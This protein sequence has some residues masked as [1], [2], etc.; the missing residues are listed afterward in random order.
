MQ[1]FWIIA[2]SLLTV[3]ALVFATLNIVSLVAHEEVTETATFDAAG[4]DL[5][6]VQTDNGTIEVVGADVDEI[7]VVA[8]ISH[9]LLRTE[10]RAEVEGGTLVVG[11][12]CADLSFSWCSVDYD[13][14]VPRD[15]VV[16]A[17]ADNGRVTL[18][19]LA[20][21]VTVDSDNGRIELLRVGGSVR[22]ST[23]NGSVEGTGLR[24][25]E[26]TATS[27]NGSVRLS[28]AEAPTMVTARTSNGSVE[29]TVP[30]DDTAYR[31]E[32]D[33]DHGSTDAGVRTDPDSRHVIIATTSNGSARVQYATG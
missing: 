16:D 26:V 8:D 17:D 21:D 13:I 19:D 32:L 20:G 11:A 24:G 23:D 31:V 27:S 15:L 3:A 2:G 25:P 4:I 7:S 10:H 33:T 5:L 1:R 9:G 28:F 29:V 12:S 18:R 14:V 30:H 6:D 22:A